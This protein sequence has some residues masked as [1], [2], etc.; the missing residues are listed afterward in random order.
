MLWFQWTFYIASNWDALILPA[1]LLEQQEGKTKE[2]N[3]GMRGVNSSK[4]CL[5]SYNNC[6]WNEIQQYRMI[7]GKVAPPKYLFCVAMQT[8]IDQYTLIEQSAY[9]VLLK[10]GIY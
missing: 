9:L 6:A 7:K 10:I 5:I 3:I 4:I 1:K 8:E 2:Q